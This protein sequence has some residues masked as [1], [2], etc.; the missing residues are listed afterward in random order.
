MRLR[1]LPEAPASARPPRRTIDARHGSRSCDGGFA[2]KA[3][4]RGEDTRGGITLTC[5][6]DIA[7]PPVGSP[8]TPLHVM[9]SMA[10]QLNGIVPPSG[11]SMVQPADYAGAVPRGREGGL[12]TTTRSAYTADFSSGS[13][14]NGRM[15]NRRCLEWALEQVGRQQNQIAADCFC[16]PSLVQRRTTSLQ[17]IHR[18]LIDENRRQS[19]CLRNDAQLA[20]RSAQS[21]LAMSLTWK[22]SPSSSLVAARTGV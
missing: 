12:R 4:G 18:L 11:L 20:I 9:N 14:Q 21:F 3:R 5:A 16:D 7:S 1:M 19:E 6:G 17:R 10:P 8:A 22:V 15:I 13:P 2:I